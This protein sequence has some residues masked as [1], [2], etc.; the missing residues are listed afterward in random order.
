MGNVYA[1]CRIIITFAEKETCETLKLFEKLT[2]N[3]YPNFVLR[4]P[5]VEKHKT[6]QW[7][8]QDLVR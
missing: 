8:Q 3:F 7:P 4:K 6:P 1:L 2:P 5:K